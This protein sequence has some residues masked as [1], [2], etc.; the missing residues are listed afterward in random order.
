MYHLWRPAK[1]GYNG[2]YTLAFHHELDSWN[3][4]LGEPKLTGEKLGSR[5]QDRVVIPRKETRD[6]YL[7]AETIQ[8]SVLRSGRIFS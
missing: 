4:C 7:V 8:I 5:F 6:I 3:E 2:W 1:G